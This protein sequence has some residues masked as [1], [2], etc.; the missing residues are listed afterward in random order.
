MKRRVAITGIGV[1]SPIGKNKEEYWN[2]LAGGKSGISILS[3]FDPTGFSCHVAGEIKDFKPK[4]YID[5]KKVKK[6]DRFVQFA[7]A[8]AKQALEDSGLDLNKEDLN[9]IGVIVGSGIGGLSTIEK[10][11]EI[12]LKK[13]PRKVSPFLIPMMI[14]N[15]AAGEVAITFG[16]KGP[17]YNI[18]SACATGAHSIGDALRIIEYGDADI[19]VAGGS[20]ASITPLGYAGFCSIK[21]LTLRNDAPQKASRPFDKERDGFVMSEGGGIVVLEEW[22]RAIGRGARIYG[23]LIGYGATDDAYHMT[24]P[25]PDGECAALAMKNALNDAGINPEEVDYINAHGTS[26]Q[27]NDK[28]ETLAIKKVF[29]N[30][31]KS[32][33]ISSTKSMTGHLLGAAGA[34]ELIAILLSMEKGIIHPTINYEYP[35][36]E[37]DLDYVPNHAR[38]KK[39]KV[40]ISN[41]LGFGGHNATLVVRK[42]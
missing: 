31:A 11:L 24:A 4:E 20:E 28:V 13:G 39:I 41:S 7:L 30:Y 27:L 9:R 1:F 33:P 14:T 16:L 23:E 29:G 35:D 38:D 42:V 26:T 37:C 21:A 18:S 36:P 40:G 10:Q 2:S 6:T 19:M 3:Y 12:L 22:N 15:M 34:I 32:I 8:A 17:N 5:L 25:A